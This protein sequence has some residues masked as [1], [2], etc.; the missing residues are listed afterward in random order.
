MLRKVGFNITPSHLLAYSVA[1]VY[2]GNRYV[3]GLISVIF[4]VMLG[5]NTWLL[6]TTGRESFKEYSVIY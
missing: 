2:H 5:I 1:A 4:L 3:L 6:T